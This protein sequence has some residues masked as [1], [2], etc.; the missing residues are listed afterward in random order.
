MARLT[1]YI[2]IIFAILSLLSCT[3]FAQNT[4]KYKWSEPVNL[5]ELNTNANDFAPAWNRFENILY[6][7]SDI[8]K[9][10]MFYT[11]HEQGDGKF[12]TPKLL[13]D[14]I[15]QPGNNQS[16]ITFESN[17]VAYISTFR[18]N[19]KRSYLNIYQTKYKRQ[20]WNKPTL[21]DSLSYD[22]FSAQAT[23]SPD[24]TIMVFSSARNSGNGDADLWMAFKQFNGTWGSII[25]LSEINS[26]G[27]EITPFLASRD[28][29]YFASDGQEGPGG[30][31]LFMSVYSDGKWG[32][33]YPL[34]ELNTNFD[35]SDITVLPGGEIIF[36]SNRPGGKGK[37]DLYFS[38]R[39]PLSPQKDSTG[40][41][42]ELTM[43][44]QATSI[45]TKNNIF[46]QALL[47]FN[48]FVAEKN[49]EPE[50]F[51]IKNNKPMQ[52]DIDSTYKYSLFMIAK[53]LEQNPQ[54]FLT[55]HRYFESDPANSLS[56]KIINFFV[57]HF[58]ISGDRLNIDSLTFASHHGEIPE[59]IK[60]VVLLSSPDETIFSTFNSE[61]NNI[62]INPPVLEFSADARPR[63]E[64]VNWRCSM[65]LKNKK[66]DSLAGGNELP[67]EFSIDLK[68]YKN[69]LI[70]CDSFSVSIYGF[71]S[72][73]RTWKNEM[74]FNLSH[75]E[76]K[77]TN[78]IDIGKKAYQQYLIFAYDVSLFSNSGNT[79]DRIFQQIKEKAK[80]KKVLV[81]YQTNSKDCLAT[82]EAIAKKIKQEGISVKTEQSIFSEKYSGKF[83]QPYT[84]RI[85]IEK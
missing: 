83:L 21:A 13:N 66:Y 5:S 7:N 67:A 23:V 2:K 19:E 68:P 82:A 70:N 57:N 72:E 31:D 69:E 56:G 27:N 44:V 62:T 59:N 35:E 1:A 78:I 45:M 81:Q 84:F 16:Y 77:G 64:I 75:T 6:F 79:F 11:S 9:Y 60:S 71:D 58:N 80:N 25:N 54:S 39:V 49:S 55:I 52:F 22:A 29:L 48:F 4:P 76:I 74:A 17:D 20:N 18:L 12:S 24:G 32:R 30:F 40:E 61:E 85:L 14:E 42:V 43:A 8:S 73:G 28:T 47:P 50:I 3:V 15:N 63:K 65:T 33:P 26:P 51:G 36:A 41:K 10:S 46:T 38:K 53:R 37:L 34:T